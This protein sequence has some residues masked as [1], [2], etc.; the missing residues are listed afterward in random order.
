MVDLHS[1]PQRG[2]ELAQ[3][4]ADKAKLRVTQP[5]SWKLPKQKSSIAPPGVWTNAD[6]GKKA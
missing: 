6:Q 1:L 5:S 2:Q 3:H 4:A